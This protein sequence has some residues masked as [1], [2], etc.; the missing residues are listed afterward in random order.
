MRTRLRHLRDGG[1]EVEMEAAQ[2]LRLF[3][4]A[5]VALW[6]RRGQ[7]PQSADSGNLMRSTRIL[8]SVSF[9]NCSSIKC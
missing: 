7:R 4:K 5:T 2:R 9:L 6:S 3:V 1:N 8:G